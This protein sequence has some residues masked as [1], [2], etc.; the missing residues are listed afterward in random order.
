MNTKDDVKEVWQIINDISKKLKISEIDFQNKNEIFKDISKN[1]NGFALIDYD[2]LKN[3]SITINNK[4]TPSFVIKNYSSN[5]KQEKIRLYQGRVLIKDSDD[6]DIIKNGDMNEVNVKTILEI[7]SDILNRFEIK[8]GALVKLTGSSG[9]EIKGKVKVLNDLNNSI[10][11]TNLFGEMAIEM[12]N[13]NDKDWSMNIPKL[14]YEIIDN[15]K[16]E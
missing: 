11:I 8:E 10:S 12:Q 3:E 14:D 1:I 2:N 7:S 16:V 5:E 6:I 13:S 9:Y 15:L 4:I